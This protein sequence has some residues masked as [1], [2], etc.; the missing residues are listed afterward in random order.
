MGLE[1]LMGVAVSLALMAAMVGQ[2]PTVIGVVRITQ[3]ELIKAS[4]T[5]N[6]GKAP[7]LPL[8]GR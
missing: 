3:L 8:G 7:L 6:W 5:S 1:K 4:Q 2:L